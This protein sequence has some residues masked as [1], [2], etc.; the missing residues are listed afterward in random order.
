MHKAI[1]EIITYKAYEANH[2]VTYYKRKTPSGIQ[3]QLPDPKKSKIESDDDSIIEDESSMQDE[4]VN[5][6]VIS[7]D[8]IEMK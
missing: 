4:L 5:T 6:D 8:D 7:D 2:L 3:Q 1:E